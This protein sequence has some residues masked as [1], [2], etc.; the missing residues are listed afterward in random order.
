MKLLRNKEI[1]QIGWIQAFSYIDIQETYVDIGWFSSEIPMLKTG[2]VTI[3]IT[4]IGPL[5][6]SNSGQPLLSSDTL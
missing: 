3:V 6:D 1:W 2:N 4:L 5:L